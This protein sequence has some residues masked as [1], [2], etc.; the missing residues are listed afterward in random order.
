M[1]DV[2]LKSHNLIV[3][4]HLLVEKFM[5][6]MR[7]NKN[8]CIYDGF[9]VYLHYT[10]LS[11]LVAFNV[12]PGRQ[13]KTI[14]TTQSRDAVEAFASYA[15]ET[16]NDNMQIVR[17]EKRDGELFPVVYGLDDMAVIIDQGLD[18]R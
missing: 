14:Y 8:L 3:G 4:H 12:S 11:T 18:I 15:V 13:A 5:G 1:T 16:N 17:I 9:G 6:P 7:A 2:E 10:V